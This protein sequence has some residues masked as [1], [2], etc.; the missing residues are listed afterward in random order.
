[1][2]RIALVLV[3]AALIPTSLVA[4]E[5]DRIWLG[6]AIL[7]MEDE[8]MRADALAVRPPWLHLPTPLARAGAWGAEQA[9]RLLGFSPP[10]SVEGVRFFTESRAFSIA[11]A[12]RE[13][14][15]RPHVGIEE[16]TRRA[17]AWYGEQGLL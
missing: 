7:T 14:G 4:Q 17:A 13:L 10:L 16:G 1:M 12:A 15:W 5:A 8:A 2:L 9:G 11:K 3:L 6:G